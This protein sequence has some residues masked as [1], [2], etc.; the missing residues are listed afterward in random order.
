MRRDITI[1][2]YDDGRCLT[3]MDNPSPVVH[4]F[5]TPSQAMFYLR[6]L[7]AVTPWSINVRDA[8]PKKKVE[9]VRGPMR[10]LVDGRL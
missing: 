5:D 1:W 4:S 10:P 3:R 7:T 8:I 9:Q 6:G 2:M